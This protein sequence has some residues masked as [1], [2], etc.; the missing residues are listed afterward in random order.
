MTNEVSPRVSR[1]TKNVLGQLVVCVWES[2]LCPYILVRPY[3]FL[4]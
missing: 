1:K 2:W 4:H 3:F